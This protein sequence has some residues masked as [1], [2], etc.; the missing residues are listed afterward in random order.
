[1]SQLKNNQ[2]DLQIKLSSMEESRNFFQSEYNCLQK[3]VE[4]LEEIQY[5]LENTL[6]T[7]EH[8]IDNLQCQL[9]S[10]QNQLDKL[11]VEHEQLI[12]DYEKQISDLI[13]EHT[14]ELAKNNAENIGDKNEEKENEC[15]FINNAL[16]RELHDFQLIYEDVSNEFLFFKHSP[17][18]K[19]FNYEIEKINYLFSI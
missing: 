3:K 13:D 19:K 7:R 5:D 10:V 12:D 9:L 15:L 4:L 17:I 1:M 18:T 2:E 6:E 8:I 16:S 11:K 14:M